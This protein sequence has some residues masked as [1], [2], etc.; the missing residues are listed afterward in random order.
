MPDDRGSLLRHY[1]EMR[2]EFL[3]AVEGLDDAALAEP[4]L[5][6]WS[7]KDHMLHVA[8]WD[9]LRAEDMRRISAGH[10]TAWK[11]EDGGDDLNAIVYDRRRRLSVAQARWELVSTH[12]A[13]L[14]AIEQMTARGFDG[15]LYGEMN[16]RGEHEAVHT[17]W[18]RR[19]RN[20]RGL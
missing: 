17:D 18:I 6:G 8:F 9:G 3:A 11:L 2:A 15:S 10:D 16:L 1:R 4:S 13:V 5:D 12:E 14:S 7:V 19:W 20:E